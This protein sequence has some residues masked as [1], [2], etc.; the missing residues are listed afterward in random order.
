M[1]KGDRSTPM[2][3]ML[4]QIIIGAANLSDPHALQIIGVAQATPA[5]LLPTPT[6]HILRTE[7]RGAEWGCEI[8]LI[9]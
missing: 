7:F 4:S 6:Y 2:F 8:I 1:A 9:L 3:P 5:A